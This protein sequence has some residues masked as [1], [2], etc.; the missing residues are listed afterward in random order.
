MTAADLGDALAR[1]NAG[2]NTLSFLLLITG[3]VSIRQKNVP[4]HR[5]FMGAAFVTSSLFLIGYLTR[6]AL[7]GAHHIAATGAVKALYLGLLFSH[8]VLAATAVPFILRALFLALKGRFPEHRKI[9]RITFPIWAY[10]SLTGVIVYALLYH[11]VGTAEAH[12]T[13]VAVRLPL[14]AFTLTDQESRPF[15]L[16]QMKGHV[17]VADFVFTS[18]PTVCP[19]LTKRMVEVQAR[20][21]PLGD[22]VHLVTISVDPENDTPARL[23]AY[24]KEHGADPARWTFLTGPLD[25]IEGT[26]TNGFKMVMGKKES[27]PGSSL[28]TIFHGEKFVLVDGEGSIRGFYDADDE[29]LAALVGAAER[30]ARGR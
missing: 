4:R 5:L 28:M 10:V 19:K 1:L 29:G 2:L 6:F 30:L 20:T 16:A 17:W 18:C 15:G 24:G 9:A 27:A 22:A 21:R 12:A 14:P 25:Q 26:V 7:T 11:V 13:P 8:M 23:A 3:W